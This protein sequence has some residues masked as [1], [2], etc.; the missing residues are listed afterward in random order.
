[1]EEKPDIFYRYADADWA[2]NRDDHTCSRFLEESSAGAAENNRVLHF[3]QRR[4]SLLH[5]LRHA[6]KS[7][8]IF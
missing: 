1:M 2:E 8:T 6:K 4:Q 5:L 7:P 3:L